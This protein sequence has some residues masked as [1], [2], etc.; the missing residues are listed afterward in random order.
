MKRTD[1]IDFSIMLD[2]DNR[3]TKHGWWWL[4][5]VIGIYNGV[6]FTLLIQQF[7]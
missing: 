1:F 2:E 4:G 7:I 3:L 5:T 6:V